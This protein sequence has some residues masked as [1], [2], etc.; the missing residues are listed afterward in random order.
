V[1][2]TRDGGN[3]WTV[4]R[5][6][7]GNPEISKLH[8]IN[9]NVGWALRSRGSYGGVLMYTTDGGKSWDY[10]PRIDTERLVDFSDIYFDSLN[11]WAVGSHN[12]ILRTKNYGGLSDVIS[13]RPPSHSKQNAAPFNMKLSSVKTQK[14]MTKINYSLNT[15]SLFS[16]SVYNLKGIKVASS[17]KRLKPMGDHSFSFKTP[18]GFYIVE[19]VLHGKSGEAIKL[20]EKVFVR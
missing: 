4:L 8:F 9:E 15:E 10:E 19:A 12:S 11:G 7:P 1:A 6:N 13:V 14:G 5:N 18:K 2:G 17:P 20:S 3:T 16:L